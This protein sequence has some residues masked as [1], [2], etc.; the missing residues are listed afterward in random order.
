M[1]M[2]IGSK[3]TVGTLKSN[4]FEESNPEEDAASVEVRLASSDNDEE[5][6]AAAMEMEGEEE[7]H[8]AVAAGN[9]NGAGSVLKTPTG[10]Q[11]KAA[12]ESSDD[13]SIQQTKA[14]C[15]TSTFMGGKSKKYLRVGGM[16]FGGCALAV[17]VSKS[18]KGI[19][20]YNNSNKVMS[21]EAIAVVE[22][23][24]TGFDFVGYGNCLDK[25]DAKYDYVVS[26]VISAEECAEKCT[27]CPG[28]GQADSKALL[29]FVYDNDCPTCYCLV[30]NGGDFING[31]CGVYT[32]VMTGNAG[33]GEITDFTDGNPGNECWKV[34]SK[35]S[36]SSKSGRISKKP[37]L[38]RKLGHGHTDMRRRLC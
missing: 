15:I 3:G 9:N 13:G 11:D 18:V 1:K 38:I 20:D 10:R 36:K 25:D 22:E 21:A 23:D 29:G 34:N 30:E 35:S 16:C 12:D 37:K 4:H 2:S 33:T 32:Y 28:G 27:G 6:L 19:H 26:S 8:A 7:A 31:V 5:K 14:S 17:I 24:I